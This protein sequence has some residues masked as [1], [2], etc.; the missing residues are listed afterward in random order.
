MRR[1]EE[2]LQTATAT[3]HAAPVKILRQQADRA[4]PC[5]PSSAPSAGV[6]VSAAIALLVVDELW[7]LC[8]FQARRRPQ[9]LGVGC[10]RSHQ[11]VSS[12]CFPFPLPPLHRHV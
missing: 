9:S 1:Q 12:E 4:A 5:T 8:C 11:V 3:L 7:P 6:S 2:R 10:S